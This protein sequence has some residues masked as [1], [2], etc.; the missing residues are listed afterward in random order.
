MTRIFAT[1]ILVS[2]NYIVEYATGHR[3]L[4]HNVLVVGMGLAIMFCSAS[5]R[6]IAKALYAKGI[7]YE[8]G[9]NRKIRA[10]IMGT[11]TESVTLANKLKHEIK[12]KYEPVAFLW[13]KER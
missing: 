9:I 3:V 8:A 10:I 6:V 5:V 13:I 11:D 2:N 1:I 12:G 4:S 7:E